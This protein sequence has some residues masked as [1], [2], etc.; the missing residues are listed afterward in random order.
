MSE[1]LIQQMKLI[2]NSYNYPVITPPPS[3]GPPVILKPLHEEWDTL[4]QKNLEIDIFNDLINELNN[5]STLSASAPEWSPVQPPILTVPTEPVT[6]QR[7]FG[8]PL[9]SLLTTPPP[10]PKTPPPL[11]KT[12][13]TT[14][15]PP[16]LS[17]MQLK[18]YYIFKYNKFPINLPINYLM[19]ML[20][21][22]YI[23]TT[24]FITA[25]IIN[26]IYILES[27]YNY[28]KLNYFSIPN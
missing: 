11:P 20:D 16:L 10:L 13:L 5:K 25:L 8:A 24:E 3:P 15:L 18:V 19:K 26:N 4:M 23:Y 21:I 7:F 2:I 14:M 17:N 27:N 28:I 6:L 12:P 9:P 22:N 1:D